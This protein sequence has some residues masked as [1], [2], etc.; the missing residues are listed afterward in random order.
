M[1]GEF[2]VEQERGE[3]GRGKVEAASE[4]VDL[5]GAVGEGGQDARS[6]V[7]NS[8]LAHGRARA[9]AEC[10]AQRG[11]KRGVEQVLCVED[12]DRAVAEEFVGTAVALGVDRAGDHEHL[13]S[14][15]VRVTRGPERTAARARFDH[16]RG[17]GD[18]TDQAVA[19]GEAG[20][21]RWYVGR[22]LGEP[23]ATLREDLACE[24]P[25]SGGR[26]TVEARGQERERRTAAV[27]RTSVRGGVDSVGE[28]GDDH[29]AG[30]GEA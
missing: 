3:S 1:A 21:K 11:G 23:A 9:A 27:E 2:E 16:E 29:R 28:A 19:F 24:F 18:A 25:V 7:R 22:V 13:A 12:R 10:V 30:F 6:V 26:G 17:A 5:D 20:G 4:R 14:L 15:F 8:G